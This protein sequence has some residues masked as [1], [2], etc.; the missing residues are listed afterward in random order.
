MSDRFS[1][2]DHLFNKKSVTYF[3]DLFY[4][5][6]SNFPKKQF[7]KNIIQDFPDLELK[8]RISRM[9]KELKVSLPKEYPKA[10]KII[11]AALPP[12]LDPNKKDD[13]FGEFILAP[14]SQYIHEQG[15][16][17]KYLQISLLAL[18][19]CTKRFSVEFSI[20]H[21]INTFPEETFD[22]LLKNT[23]SKNYHVRRLSSEGL[24]PQL[25]WAIGIDMDYKKPV[26]ILDLLFFDSTRYVTRSVANHMNDI[27]K[28][29]P[30]Y[31]IKILKTWKKT[32]K[33]NSKEM[34]YILN[35]SL[36]TLIKKGNTLALELLGYS[37]NPDI[38]I[39]NLTIKKTEIQLGKYL[40]FSFEIKSHKKQ[41]LLID[42]VVQYPHPSGRISKKIF[43]IKNTQ[44]IKGETLIITKKQPFRAMTT[45]KLYPGQYQC[46]LQING[47][48]YNNFNFTLVI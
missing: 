19:E 1:L 3:A 43:K 12:E 38:S 13:D 31:T 26:Q 41:K 17:K 29:D 5:N 15:C 2:K 16:N 37:T 44:F 46:Q 9:T 6:N 33:Q 23:Q 10:L 34:D 20:R 4:I 40:D 45:K 35:H 48:L 36:R 47:K 42:Y 11:L 32:N 25:P 21:F 22:I 39:H 24:R 27:S 8:E 28:I 18:I 30:E 7:I 14:L